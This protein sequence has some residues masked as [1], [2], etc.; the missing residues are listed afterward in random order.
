MVRVT[1]FRVFSDG[2]GE[3][4]RGM[5]Q[6]D[7]KPPPRLEITVKQMTAVEEQS[8][9]WDIA[10]QV[11]LPGLISAKKMKKHRKKK[12]EFGCPVGIPK[13]VPSKRKTSR[14][15]MGNRESAHHHEDPTTLPQTNQQGHKLHS[16]HPSVFTK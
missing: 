13:K 10:L 16:P 12:K 1:R 6:E 15:D 11:E 8:A 7:L 5:D 2:R 4:I 3:I 14:T 9:L